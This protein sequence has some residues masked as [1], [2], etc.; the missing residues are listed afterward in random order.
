[1]KHRLVIIVVCV[2]GLLIISACGGDDSDV[3]EATATRNVT[4]VPTLTSATPSIA[5]EVRPTLEAE[6]DELR[7]AQETITG[8]WSSLQNGEEVSCADELPEF[9]LPQAYQR[10]DVVSDLLFSA[11]VHLDTAYR[12][13]EAECQNP[14]SQPPP[15]VI[16]QGLREA[17]AAG[18]DLKDAGLILSN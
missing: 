11:A 2:L 9:G 17:L 4:A 6:F 12:L 1:M 15:E 14:R 3:N 7:T 10:D 18:D 5:P 8:I 13:W 16:D